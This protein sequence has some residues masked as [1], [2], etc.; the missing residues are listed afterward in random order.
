VRPRPRVVFLSKRFLHPLDTGG[1]IRTAKLLEQLRERWQIT[2]VGHYDAATDAPGRAFV[3]GLAERFVPVPKPQLPARGPLARL[4]SRTRKFLSPLPLAV[5]YD[6]DERLSEALRTELAGGSDLLVCDFVQ[7][8]ANV[9]EPPGAASLLFTH[10]VETRILRRQAEV[11]RG[12]HRLFW[13]L[14]HRRMR[15]FEARQC[16]RYDRVV[17]VSDGDRAEFE[18]EFGLRNVRTIP[19]GVDTTYFRPATAAPDPDLIAFCGSMDY[20]PNR[21]GVAWFA[22]DVLP[23]IRALRPGARL[24]VVGRR[25][26]DDLVSRL[27]AAAVEFTGWVDD[28]RPHLCRASVVV[29]PLRVGGGTRIKIYEAMALGLPVVSTTLGAE[30]LPLEPGRH[31]HRADLPEELAGGVLRALDDPVGARAMAER[32]RDY[33]RSQFAWDRVAATFAQIGDEAMAAR[34]VRVA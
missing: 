31:Y 27:S 34:G 2:L 1:K 17:A 12:A 19:T 25:P 14:Q 24:L 22:T 3:E 21:D 16:A 15:R 6:T 28:V 13:T 9:P 5:L 29:V 10:N 18:R 8:S 11:E 32:A 23:R 30:G 20:L 26:G 4:A 7:S 33:V